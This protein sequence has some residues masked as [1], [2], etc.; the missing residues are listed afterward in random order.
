MSDVILRMNATP[1]Y[2]FL[3]LIHT[4]QAQGEAPEG[5]RILDCGAGGPL[6][7]LALFDQHG[8]DCWG[9]DLSEE[10]L[11]KAE[12]FCQEQGVDLDLRQGDMCSLPFDDESFDYVYEHY[13][14]CH[15]S[16]PDTAR[17]IGEMHRVLRKGGLCF[18]G[19]ISRDSW[20]IALYGEEREPGEFWMIEHGDELT[21]H[22]LFSDEEAA[23][24]VANWEIELH[25]KYVRHMRAMAEEKTPEEWMD[26][27]DEAPDGTTSEAWGE[28]YEKRMQAFR[29]VHTYYFLRKPT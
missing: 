11:R 10:Q 6:P 8:F 2:R 24:L 4:L 1:V 14:M 26:L 13:S 9:I 15:L 19:L 17:A 5:R 22:S 16:K 23:Q 18:L 28:R 7:P 3:S 27:L 25:E 21:R 20:P 29:Y 12:E